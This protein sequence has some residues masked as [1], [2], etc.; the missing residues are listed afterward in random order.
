MRIKL[1]NDKFTL[2]LFTLIQNN[3]LQLCILPVL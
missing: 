1:R 3:Y 2:T